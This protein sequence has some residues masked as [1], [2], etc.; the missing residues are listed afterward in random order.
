MFQDLCYVKSIFKESKLTQFYDSLKLFRTIYFFYKNSHARLFLEYNQDLTEFIE[1]G[2]K[3]ET[4]H[5]MS[6]L[7]TK[8]RQ[9]S[10]EIDDQMAIDD[11]TYLWNVS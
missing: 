8:E 3:S 1:N 4:K 2:L 11:A 6:A 9:Y 10:T 7:V 5:L